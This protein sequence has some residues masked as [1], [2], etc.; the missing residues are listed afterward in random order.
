MRVGQDIE[1]GGGDACASSRSPLL[2]G[3]ASETPALRPPAVLAGSAGRDARLAN[4]PAPSRRI[5]GHHTPAPLKPQRPYPERQEGRD[6][7][8]LTSSRIPEGHPGEV[9]VSDE[10]VESARHRQ[11]RSVMKRLHNEVPE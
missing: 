8:G 2:R 7:E 11:Q 9:R 6:D 4:T 1:G 10:R 5:G 3:H